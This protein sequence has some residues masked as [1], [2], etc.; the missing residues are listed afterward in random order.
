MV[1]S[2]LLTL[3]KIQERATSNMVTNRTDS[4]AIDLEGRDRQNPI[5][6]AITIQISARAT[7][8]QDPVIREEFKILME[9]LSQSYQQLTQQIRANTELAN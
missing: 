3:L 9:E 8:P 5:H 7:D 1:P 6:L 2:I 4:N